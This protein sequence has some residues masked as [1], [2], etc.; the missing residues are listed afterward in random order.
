MR[1]EREASAAYRAL[2]ERQQKVFVI[3]AEAIGD[4]TYADVSYP[5]LMASTRLSQAT[6]AKSLRVLAALGLLAVDVGGH[7]RTRVAL[8]A[9]W[10]LVT[11][12]EAEKLAPVAARRPPWQ[13]A[14]P[15]PAKPPKVIVSE[16]DDEHEPAQQYQT[17]SLPKLRFLGEL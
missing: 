12:D 15:K 5:W 3:I 8:S 17:P 11:A 4:R 7:R 2:T 1:R 14:A 16:A 9:R 10:R 6:V 13:P